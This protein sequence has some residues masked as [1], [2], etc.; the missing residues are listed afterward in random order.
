MSSEPGLGDLQFTLEGVKMN[1]DNQFVDKETKRT[2]EWYLY[3]SRFV[4]VY[5]NNTTGKYHYVRKTNETDTDNI[6]HKL[7]R[8][9]IESDSIIEVS[10]ETI[11]SSY[12]YSS[13]S[14]QY[15]YFTGVDEK[16]IRR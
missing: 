6:L 16:I 3:P 13:L 4:E 9:T 10:P 7:P 2:I 5:L 8:F 12:G 14:G 1:K 15:M 11:D